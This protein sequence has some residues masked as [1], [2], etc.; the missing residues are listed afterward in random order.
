MFD[1][2]RLPNPIEQ[3]V[4]DWVRLNFII[5]TI[6]IMKSHVLFLRHSALLIGETEFWFDFV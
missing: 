4:F 1:Y 3:L 2:I 5:I 6:M